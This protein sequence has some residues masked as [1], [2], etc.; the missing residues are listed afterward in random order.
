[1]I[2]LRNFFKVSVWFGWEAGLCGSLVRFRALGGWD[3]SVGSALGS[4]SCLM[5]HLG[6]DPPLR[7]FFPVER[8]FS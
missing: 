7:R 8:I 2:R 5:Q 1:M 6:F 4:L 3:S